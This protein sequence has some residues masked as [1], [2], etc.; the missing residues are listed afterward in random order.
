[1]SIMHVR[2]LTRHASRV[3][4]YWLVVCLSVVPMLINSCAGKLPVGAGFE[5]ARTDIKTAGNSIVDARESIALARGEGSSE[6][7]P[8]EFAQAESLLKEAQEAL[9]KGKN[10]DTADLAFQA[11]VEAKIA[12]ALAR[13]VNAKRRAEEA[14]ETKLKIMWEAKTDEVA[15]AKA[16]RA[17]AEKMA[18]EAQ[19]EAERA[20]ERADKEI[21]RAKIELAIA[22]VEL[23][24]DLADQRKASEYAKES[25]TKARTWLQ[26]AKSA[27]ARPDDFQKAITATEEAT[28]YISNALVQAKAKLEA[29]A[30]E[31]VKRRDRAVAAI[32]KAEVS[33]EG[34]KETL[35]TQYAPAMYEKAEKALKEAGLALEVKEY[36][37]AGSMADK[38]RVS[39][40]SAQAV[41]KAKEGEIQ[42]REAQEDVKANALDAAAKAER[43]IAEAHTAGAAE[44]AG[45]IYNQA[46]AALDRTRQAMLEENFEE[47]LSSARESISHSATA[48][49]MA[50]AKTEHKRKI[51]EIESNIMEEAGKI[52]SVS[53]RGTNRGVVISMGGVLF[54]QGS[55]QIRNDARARLKMLVELLKRYP[56][57]KIITEGHTDSVG[58]E[59]A[60]LKISSERAYNFLRYMVDREG[61]PLERLSSV[62]Y[63]ESRPIAS[64]INEAG[65]R[66]NRRVDI[67]ILTTPVSP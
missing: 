21:Q 34:A 7:A 42:A 19:K 44:L 17:I 58:P 54:A 1:M 48:L 6:H 8:Q 61:I 46:Q 60:N 9:R 39:A 12:I 50:R 16:R 11:D 4:R 14:R 62:G 15:A 43:A 52:P 5:S 31:S 38:A 27:L 2:L 29:E 49:A 26:A 24:I 28:G 18:L 66:Q 10:R 64:N 47:A 3:T 13:E 33:L 55:S 25:Y 32:T 36:D 56:D 30:E 35:A 67:V 51:E 20:R 23:E 37:R 65:R 45:D 57:Y 40:S 22:R 41:A 59:E 63:G 53:V